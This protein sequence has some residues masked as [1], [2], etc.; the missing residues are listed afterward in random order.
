MGRTI[1]SDVIFVVLSIGFVFAWLWLHTGSWACAVLGMVMILLC[2]PVGLLLTYYVFG[3]TYFNQ[4]NILVIFLVLGIGA[5][6]IFVQIDAFKYAAS[7]VHLDVDGNSVE[8]LGAGDQTTDD[9]MQALKRGRTRV[10]GKRLAHALLRSTEA[11]MCTSVTTICAFAATALSPLTS[12]RAFGVFASVTIAVLFFLSFTFLPAVIAC[13]AH[14]KISCCCTPLNWICCQRH[15]RRKLVKG[16]RAKPAEDGSTAAELA[17]EESTPA[18]KPSSFHAAASVLGPVAS[19]R[20]IA[21]VPEQCLQPVGT[22]TKLQHLASLQQPSVADR[23][24]PVERLQQ[25]MSHARTPTT[26]AG[27]LTA[28]K[29]NH[30]VAKLC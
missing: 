18:Q 12:L 20:S 11:V 8:I 6:N 28:A 26:H 23:A 19:L 7:I 30:N 22:H 16:K 3:V 24:R 17:D 9:M 27:A 13:V 29:V 25:N 14:Y 10:L 5:D 15:R 2:F 21:D 1:N 4:L